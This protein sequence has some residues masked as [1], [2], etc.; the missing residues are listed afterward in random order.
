MV[1]EINDWSLVPPCPNQNIVGCK[2]VFRIKRKVDGSIKQFKAHLIAK[3]FH[4]REGVD[5]E[6]T[7]SPVV[8][9][10]TIHTILSIAVSKGW[11]LYKLDVQNAFLHGT[12]N[13]EVYM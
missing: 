3:G 10:Y 13:K 1:E 11:H 5:F 6:E 4:Q 7:F 8:K 2:W 9:P 12:L